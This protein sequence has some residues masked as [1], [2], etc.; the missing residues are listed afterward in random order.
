MFAVTFTGAALPLGL[1]VFAAPML[2][3]PVALP[4]TPP[5]AAVP[6]IVSTWLL[7]PL[8]C[9]TTPVP[10]LPTLAVGVTPTIPPLA[11]VV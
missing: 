2:P 10:L 5:T 1:L 8:G 9:N 6:L 7:P 11:L 3:I 4:L